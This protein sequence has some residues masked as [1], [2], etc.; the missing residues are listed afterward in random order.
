MHQMA[1]LRRLTLRQVE[2]FKAVIENGGISAAADM[3]HIS[4]PAMSK[5]ITH[6]EAD[7]GLKLF[8][9]AKGRLAPT[10]C[11]MR[12][13]EKID[14]IFAGVLQIE[15]A[16]DA[17]R[18]EEQGQLAI[19]VMPALAGSF[20]Q[21]STSNFLKEHPN[22]CCSVWSLSSERI[23]DGLVKRKLDVGLVSASIDNHLVTLESVMERPLVCIMAPGHPFSARSQIKPQ[24]LDGIPFVGFTQDTY[25]GQMITSML[26]AYGVKPTIVLLANVAPTLCEF[27]AGGLGVSLVHPLTLTGLEHRLVVRRF[28]PEIPYSLKLC[29]SADSRNARLV[30]AFAQALR[31]TAAQITRSISGTSKDVEAACRSRKV[32]HSSA[33]ARDF[34]AE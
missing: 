14:R 31:A 30:E 29:R 16:V 34:W 17:I 27:V 12:L 15:R 24:D 9:R 28:E 25:V 3:V 26:D 23:V 8:E 11:G 18:R 32:K 13:Y 20:I 2:A 10:E 4:Q 33:P 21:G 19:G 6:F 22:V 1:T 7:T 5:L